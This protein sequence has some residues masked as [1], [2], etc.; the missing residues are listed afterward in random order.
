MY[1]KWQIALTLQLW[2]LTLGPSGLFAEETFRDCNDC[3]EMVVVPAGSFMMGTTEAAGQLALQRGFVQYA[4]PLEWEKP[5]HQVQIAEPFALGRYEVSF[6]QWDA[7]VADGG[8]DDYRPEDE[9]W[10]RG[11]RPVINV[12]WKDAQAYVRWLSEKTGQPYRL[13]SEAEWEYAARAGTTTL[14]SWGDNIAP[15]N[16]NYGLRGGRTTE[17]GT[18]PANP[19]GLYD[20]HGNVGEWVEDCQNES[21][22]GAPSD[23]T[24]WTSGEC[25]FS[26]VLR[27]GSW[28]NYPGLLRSA[29]RSWE[30]PGSRAPGLGFRVARTLP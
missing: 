28:E 24:A 13:P 7:C 2:L 19:W 10:G 14:Y 29:G 9:G 12:S 18:Y 15:E 21:Y 8:C 17:V 6:D 22:E 23:G 5:R 25:I 3:P 30:Y 1:R 27:G 20:M 4:P 26:R 16:A 11:R